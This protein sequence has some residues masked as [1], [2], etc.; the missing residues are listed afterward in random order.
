MLSLNIHSLFV[1]NRVLAQTRNPGI[2]CSCS[3][4]MYTSA[5]ITDDETNE[6][7]IISSELLGI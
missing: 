3:G 6:L 2:H 1:R 7:L 4:C 5:L